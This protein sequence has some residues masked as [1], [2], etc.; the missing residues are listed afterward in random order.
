[1]AGSA[2]DPTQTNRCITTAGFTFD[3]GQIGSLAR[4]WILG[5]ALQRKPCG[6]ISPSLVDLATRAISPPEGHRD[7]TLWLTL[8]I[9]NGD[10]L[11]LAFLD[12]T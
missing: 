6:P 8:F 7:P 12:G 2:Q 10:L 9:Q 11:F 5:V 3:D 4:Y 1:M